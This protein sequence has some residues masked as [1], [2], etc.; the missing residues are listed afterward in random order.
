MNGQLL[1]FVNTTWSSN[2]DNKNN[3]NSSSD[4]S[5]LILVVGIDFVLHLALLFTPYNFVNLEIS[6][7]RQFGY[8][9]NCNNSGISQEYFNLYSLTKGQEFVSGLK[10]CHCDTIN[11]SI[12][13]IMVNIKPSSRTK[14]ILISMNR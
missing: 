13:D 3:C 10:G 4:W 7:D 6:R 14:F 1:R 9:L 8:Y 5:S 11:D 12:D 2:S